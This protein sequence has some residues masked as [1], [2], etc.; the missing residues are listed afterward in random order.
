MIIFVEHICPCGGKLTTIGRWK[1]AKA[2]HTAFKAAH[3]N[4]EPSW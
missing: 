3:A 4:C 2:E 1:K